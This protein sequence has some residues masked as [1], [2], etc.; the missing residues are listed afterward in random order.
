[1]NIQNANN[2]KVT[3]VTGASS[4]IGKAIALQLIEDGLTVYVAAR[5][6]EKMQDLK[7]L[8]AVVLKMDITQDNDVKRVVEQIESDHN[9]VD[10]LVNNA[11]Y[12][13]CGAVEDTSIE[14]ARRQFEVNLFGL[15]NLTKSVLPSMRA[16]KFGKIIN[17]SS[18]SGKIYSPLG[19]W[20]HATKHALEGWSDCL[21]LELAL[22]NIDVVIVEPGATKTK[23]GDVTLVPMME[24]SGNSAYSATAERIEQMIKSYEEPGNASDPSVVAKVVSQAIKAKQPKTRYIAGKNAKLLV[25]MRQFL[26]DRI[27]DKIIMNAI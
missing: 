20:Y 25:L 6:V 15:A 17:I 18:I 4:G 22:F 23:F 13:L 12:A 24:R 8:G 5:R 7:Q 1:M 19:A 14:D 2:S 16:K 27:F 26:G 3:L 11:G 9:G 21:R 10:I